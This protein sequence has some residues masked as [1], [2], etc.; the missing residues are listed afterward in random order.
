MRG[1]AVSFSLQKSKHTKKK[2]KRKKK[3]TNKQTEQ[4]ASNWF[5]VTGRIHYLS[6]ASQ[7][8]RNVTLKPHSKIFNC[9]MNGGVGVG[10]MGQESLTCEKKKKTIY[11]MEVSLCPSTPETPM[12]VSTFRST[13]V[14]HFKLWDCVE[15]LVIFRLNILILLSL[16]A[17]SC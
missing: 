1:C 15:A 3:K 7:I 14:P 17:F 5:R 4:T 8:L 6:L 10:S 16:K 13:T 9:K 2:T 12:N 11:D